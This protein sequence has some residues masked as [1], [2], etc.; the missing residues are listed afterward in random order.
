MAAWDWRKIGSPLLGIHSQS[1]YT[2]DFCYEN[3]PLW[4]CG[5]LLQLHTSITKNVPSN[6]KSRRMFLGRQ[7]WQ[8]RKF[9]EALVVAVM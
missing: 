9:N 1:R 2:I 4:P 8:K 7:I 3:H 6:S 5:L